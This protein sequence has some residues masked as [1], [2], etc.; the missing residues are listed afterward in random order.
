MFAPD[1]YF[2]LPSSA[3]LCDHMF[4]TD[5]EHPGGLALGNLS[6]VIQSN[7]EITSYKSL[8]IV[9]G[10]PCLEFINWAQRIWRRLALVNLC[11]IYGKKKE[12][13]AILNSIN[14]IGKGNNYLLK[15][16]SCFEK[17]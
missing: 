7:K 2:L 14:K 9:T 17:L 10:K 4:L 8:Y 11:T 3:P 16:T 12:F 13:T 5:R 6:D 1:L 15:R